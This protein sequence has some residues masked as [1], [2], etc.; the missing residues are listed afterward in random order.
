MNLQLN[1]NMANFFILLPL[2]Y[3]LQVPAKPYNPHKIPAALLSGGT[4]CKSM[5]DAAGIKIFFVPA[6]T[7]L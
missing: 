7:H 2:S 1:I 5:R 4:V 3:S 6:H